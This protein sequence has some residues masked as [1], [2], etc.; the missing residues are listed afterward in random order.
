MNGGFYFLKKEII[1][2]IEKK[3]LSLENDIILPLIYKKKIKGEKNNSNFLDIGTPKNLSRAPIS[4]KKIINIKAV[5]FDRDGTIN[6]DLGY[7]HK[8][9][10]FKW[11]KGAVQTIRLLNYLKI[12]VI[13]IT[14][15]SGI[16][17]GFY[18]HNDFKKLNSDINNYLKKFG[19][20]IDDWYYCPVNPDDKKNN[21]KKKLFFRKPQPGMIL[22]CMKKYQ[23]DK[24]NCF[25]IG[26]KKS[27]ALAAKSAGIKFYIKENYS[28]LNQI[29]K[30]LKNFIY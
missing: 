7:V 11:L 28:L 4:I 18:S 22:K 23:L 13:V 14:N 21:T 19:A 27:D 1:N 6:K 16:G 2:K 9:K 26:D 30:N 20:H 10:D 12:K 5:L 17:R 25:F 3:K 15:Q 8:F 24:N 29:L